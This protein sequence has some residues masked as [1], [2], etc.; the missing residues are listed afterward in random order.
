MIPR[1]AE[2]ATRFPCWHVPKRLFDKP[3]PNFLRHQAETN[4]ECLF[5]GLDIFA[6]SAGLFQSSRG[7]KLRKRAIR[8]LHD[9]DLAAS[10]QS[11]SIA[12]TAIPIATFNSG[13]FGNLRSIS[14]KPIKDG[15]LGK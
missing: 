3:G 14:S 6:D 10:W 15:G 12:G 4:G 7:L 8:A 1:G 2:V 11:P 13:L 9:I 5:N